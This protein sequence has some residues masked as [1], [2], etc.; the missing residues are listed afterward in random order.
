MQKG[1]LEDNLSQYLYVP[2]N[3][4]RLLDLQ[5]FDFCS[6]EVDVSTFPGVLEVD[7]IRIKG[8]ELKL[9]V[10]GKSAKLRA[11]TVEDLSGLPCSPVNDHP[12]QEGL[13]LYTLFQ[14]NFYACKP[15]KKQYLRTLNT[16]ELKELFKVYLYRDNDIKVH[17]ESFPDSRRPVFKHK[18]LVVKDSMVLN[19]GIFSKHWLIQLK[20][21]EPKKTFS[22]L[23]FPKMCK[24][25]A[26]M[27][28]LVGETQLTKMAT[29][30]SSLTNKVKM[31]SKKGLNPLK[32][33]RTASE[34]IVIPDLCAFHNNLRSIMRN[35]GLA[36]KKLIYDNSI[37]LWKATQS[38]VNWQEQ[39]SDS[40]KLSQL[41]SGSAKLLISTYLS[42]VLKYF[43]SKPVLEDLS[44]GFFSG[45]KS[46]L[47]V[48]IESLR[49]LKDIEA[50]CTEDLT[51]IFT[52]GANSSYLKVKN[53]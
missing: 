24:W 13:A 41:C 49:K 52:S 42:S 25:E 51:A 29:E 11:A 46:Q 7:D 8:K 16:S 32:K 12:K 50:S 19:S 44:E 28:P 22:E 35:D 39:L 48:E 27:S 34:A 4:Q 2:K 31:I 26:C 36:T 47:M 30:F 15:N 38:G 6:V 14:E 53:K 33:S 17:P 23:F 40:N 9:Q 5:N 45:P 43:S 20:Q 10:R 1:T 3:P 37:E 21:L 18:Y